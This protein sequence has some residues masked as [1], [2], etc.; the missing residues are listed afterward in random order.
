MPKYTHDSIERVRDAVDMVDLVGARTELRRAGANRMTGLCPF[1]DERTPSFGI[2]PVQKL[3]HCFGCGEGGDAIK[4][5]RE[6]EGLDFPAAIEMLADRYGVQLEVED[7]DPEEAQRRQARE[8]LYALLERTAAFY[9][10]YLWESSEAA[11]ARAYLLERGLEE[12]SLRQ[13]RVGYAP[14]AWDKVLLASR[15]AGFSNRELYDAG[16]ATKAKGEGR[17]YDRFRG[18]IMFPLADARGRVVG[19]GARAMGESR[20]AKYVNTPESELF[21]KRKQIYAADLA[22]AAAAKAGAVLVAEGYT[23]VIALHQAGFANAVAIMGTALTE[24]QVR[25]L[26]RLA[27]TAHLALDADNAG[28]EAMLRAARVAAG[29]TLELRVVPMPAGKDPADLVH[30]DGPEEVSRLVARSM[31]FVR[32]R[33]Q[34]ALAS[35]DLASAEGKDRVLAELR[36]VFEPIPPSVLREEL[37]RMV[38]DRIDVPAPL[39]EDLL[40]RGPSGAPAPAPAR[41]SPAPERAP[42]PPRRATDLASV[43]SPTEKIERQFLSF[44]IELPSA[45]RPA[46]ARVDPD[47]HFTDPVL[48]RVARHLREHLETP[49]EHLPEDDHEMADLVRQIVV[50]AGM[51]DASPAKIDAQRLQLEL[52]RIDRRLRR[53]RSEGE[54][55]ATEVAMRRQRIKAELDEA[56]ERATAT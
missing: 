15:R 56:M 44:C 47:E 31:P 46:L 33:V 48:A 55:G 7:E 3:Y 14:S 21:H 9:V 20:G 11:P 5:V 34:R 30:D 37:L 13:F 22:R 10:R 35:G 25:V 24:E 29:E 45:G 36:P 1:H 18:R 43:V 27:P 50:A 23:D 17:L 2:D 53:M 39:V 51:S 28:Q 49:T 32:F 6:T 16:L 38:A 42:E 52:G 54:V 26:R 4:F 40:R 8:R 12:A 19:F 41:P